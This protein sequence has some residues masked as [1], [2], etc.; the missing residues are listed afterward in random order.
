ME[1]LA[2]FMIAFVAASGVLTAYAAYQAVVYI[3][4]VIVE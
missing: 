1:L 2:V 4:S 3:L